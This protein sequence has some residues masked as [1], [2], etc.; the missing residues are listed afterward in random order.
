MLFQI[1]HSYTSD[2]TS[3]EKPED[4]SVKMVNILSIRSYSIL[5]CPRRRRR[6][7]GGPGGRHEDIPEL[8][9]YAAPAVG[10]GGGDNSKYHQSRAVDA[11]KL[12]SLMLRLA[13]G[14]RRQSIRYAYIIC[15]HDHWRIQRTVFFRGANF[16]EGR[17]PN[18]LPFSIFSSDLGHFIVKLL[19]IDIIFYDYLLYL[20]SRLG[21][22]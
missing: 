11:A 21:A 17:G 22:K 3:K 12:Y 4:F 6:R 9:S 1:L 13:G 5:K 14:A 19:N 20:F 7:G 2:R 18:L 16:G 8:V 15:S 10:G